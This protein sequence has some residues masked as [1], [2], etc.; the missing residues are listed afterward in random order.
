MKD[1]HPPVGLSLT[2]RSLLPVLAG[3]I[4]GSPDF[5]LHELVGDREP[6]LLIFLS[7][8]HI[9][10]ARACRFRL[11]SSGT[12]EHGKK[13]VFSSNYTIHR[14]HSQHTHTC[15]YEYMHTNPTRR[16]IFEDYDDKSSRLM[17]S[18]QVPHCRRE[19][20]LPLKAQTPLNLEKFAPTRSQTQDL[21][22]YRGSCNY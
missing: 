8:R 16:S 7:L 13:V 4:R 20:R 12:G 22:C 11:S 6:K 3:I 2:C 5:F 14:R 10:K 21:R 18:P 19:R 15:P 17:K 9:I 1:F